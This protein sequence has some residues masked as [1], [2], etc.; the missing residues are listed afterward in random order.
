MYIYGNYFEKF[1]NST[2]AHFHEDLQKR[3][4]P[5]MN[6]FILEWYHIKY[7]IYIIDQREEHSRFEFFRY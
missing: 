1:W 6:I 7:H 2:V 5:V 4:W 3:C